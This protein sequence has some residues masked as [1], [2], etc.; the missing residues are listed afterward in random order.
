MVLS[1]S[2]L[3]H[4]T[5]AV[6]HD[7][8]H[9]QYH[10][11]VQQNSDLHLPMQD[12]MFRFEPDLFCNWHDVLFHRFLRWAMPPSMRNSRFYRAFF[13]IEAKVDFVKGWLLGKIEPLIQD[14]EVP[15]SSAHD[16]LRDTF[17][18]VQ[19]PEGKPWLILPIRPKTFPTNYPLK[20]TLYMN[21]GVYLKDVGV[22]DG[23]HG[24]F[25]RTRILD[26]LAFKYQGTK[27]LYSTS[28]MTEE[29]FA[30]RFNGKA[31]EQIKAKYDPAGTF[32]T[33]FQKCFNNAYT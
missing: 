15:W 33:I 28:F 2:K 11:L 29:D 32:K 12:Y 8:Y 3:E 21:L 16:F 18:R 24:G 27:M 9:N 30:E 31:Y 23:K 17:S 4:G 22:D 6:V 19:L 7:I 25:G 26:D 10:H 20:D 1:Q 5:P 14:W 13:G